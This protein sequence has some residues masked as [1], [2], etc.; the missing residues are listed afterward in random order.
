MGDFY[1]NRAQPSGF[2]NQCK[3]CS[4]KTIKEY[5]GKSLDKFRALKKNQNFRAHLKHNF[6]ITPEAYMA[7][8]LQQN[9]KCAV[10][11]QPPRKTKLAVDHDHHTNK[12][13]GLL[14]FECNVA[15]GLLKDDPQLIRNALEYV[16]EYHA[17]YPY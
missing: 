12:I 7:L 5:R 4:R 15:L 16:G 6:G 11:K 14:H 1:C 10:C 8:L 2:S 9:G 3:S 17:D 13:R